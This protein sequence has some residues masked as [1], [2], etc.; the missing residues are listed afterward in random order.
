MSE[1]FLIRLRSLCH[2]ITDSELEAAQKRLVT[3]YL[4]TV[5]GMSDAN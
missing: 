4:K 1:N 2:S 3:Q 5:D